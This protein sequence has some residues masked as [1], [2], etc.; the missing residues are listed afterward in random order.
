MIFCSPQKDREQL[1]S[2]E[3]SS[4]SL[5]CI[6]FALSF[7]ATFCTE[8]PQQKQIL[9]FTGII[10]GRFYTQTNLQIDDK[11][12]HRV[13]DG[14]KAAR[15]GTEKNPASAVVQTEERKQELEAMFAENG[16]FFTVEV[17]E[18]RAE[19]ISE[20]ELLSN[21]PQTTVQEKLPGRNDPCV[22][23]SGKKYKKC[24]G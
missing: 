5:E 10:M 13:F 20:L 16:W 17:D 14:K 12:A 6:G 15:L 19:D 1:P 21:K 11:K 9:D 24:C 18:E 22:C 23:G 8:N 7:A 4:F 2:G 3:N